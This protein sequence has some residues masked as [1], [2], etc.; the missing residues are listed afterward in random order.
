[1][2][3]REGFEPSG[4]CVNSSARLAVVCFKPDSATYPKDV[5]LLGKHTEHNRPK[6]NPNTAPII[7]GTKGLRIKYMVTLSYCSMFVI[8]YVLDPTI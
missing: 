2:A 8:L 5:T 4:D 3:G 7:A 1:M 6:V